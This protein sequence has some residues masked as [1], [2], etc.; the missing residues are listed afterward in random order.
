[1]VTV[2]WAHAKCWSLAK[3]W[4]TH[5]EVY[6]NILNMK[7]NT[8]SLL[9]SLCLPHNNSRLMNTPQLEEWLLNARNG[10][11]QGEHESSIS[12]GWCLQSLNGFL[13]YS[14]LCLPKSWDWELILDQ[15]GKCLNCK[16]NNELFLIVFSLKTVMMN[17]VLKRKET[18]L[19]SSQV[20]LSQNP[21][22]S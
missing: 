20:L 16:L 14:C 1:M 4:H 21:L 5:M 10:T 18:G 6:G 22:W 12:L 19:S 3:Q 9:A 7:Y 15:F 8:F 13:V 2:V 11:I 17:L